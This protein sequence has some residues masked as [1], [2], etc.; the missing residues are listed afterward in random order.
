MI[1]M[2]GA[3]FTTYELVKN[4]LRD[5]DRKRLELEEHDHDDDQDDH[6]VQHPPLRIEALVD[7]E[8]D[9]PMAM[10]M[11]KL[12][13]PKAT[14]VTM[15]DELEAKVDEAE[16]ASKGGGVGRGGLVLGAAGPTDAAGAVLVTAVV[17]R[18]G[19]LTALLSSC[20]QRSAGSPVT[21]AEAEV[22]QRQPTTPGISCATLSVIQMGMRVCREGRVGE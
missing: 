7:P 5:T 8:A 20:Q 13:E 11:A 16:P 17:A 21:P 4:F 19:P 2:S 1:P 6:Y 12:D 15:A 9:K 22:R 10:A 14:V 18:D 3:S